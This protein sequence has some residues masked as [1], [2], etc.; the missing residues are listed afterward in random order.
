MIDW[1]SG[2][3]N[4]IKRVSNVVCWL[5]LVLVFFV[6]G[7]EQGYREEVSRP[8]LVAPGFVIPGYAS[9]A[10][11][12]GGGLDTWVKTEQIEVGCVA[13]FYQPDGSFYLT[14]QHYEIYPWLN[15]IRISA[16]EPQGEFVWQLS[17]G[18]FSVLEG[19]QQVDVLPVAVCEGWF[20]EAILNITTA[21]ARFLDESVEFKKASEPVKIEGQWYYSI[22]RVAPHKTGIWS[23]AVFY[24][25]R[26][27]SLVD[28]LWFADVNGESASGGLAVRGYDYRRIARDG[29]L[30]PT[31]IE[32]LNADALGALR[33]RLVKIDFE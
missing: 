32:I 13:T 10:I 18:R 16:K 4:A 3:S 28:M 17:N 31:K 14:E 2:S 5:V 33:E 19:A 21:P 29:V 22:E 30:V 25:N 9:R 20:A 27:N 7:C 15:S 8:P 11:E 6:A 26:D 24:Q 23:K 12:A 1:F